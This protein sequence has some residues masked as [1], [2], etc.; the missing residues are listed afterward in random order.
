MSEL[1]EIT[2]NP[3]L[4]AA[5]CRLLIAAYGRDPQHV[6]WS[7]MQASLTLALSAFGLPEDYPET[8]A[9]QRQVTEEE[10]VR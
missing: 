2:P 3:E 4:T 10:T 9:A 8:V 6:D 7:D 1:R 5:A